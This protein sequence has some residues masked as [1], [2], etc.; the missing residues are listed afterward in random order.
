MRR[1]GHHDSLLMN[2]F[3]N[4]RRVRGGAALSCATSGTMGTSPSTTP[5]PAAT[6]APSS[7]QTTATRR[8]ATSVRA[9]HQLRQHC[10]AAGQAGS[11]ARAQP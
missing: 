8:L 6:A 1:R 11:R 3:C 4:I 2:M 7:M 9:V 5:R 10:A